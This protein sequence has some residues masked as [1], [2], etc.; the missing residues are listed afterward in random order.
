MSSVPQGPGKPEPGPDDAAP[1]RAAVQ[2][3]RR[4]MVGA[5]ATL[6][7]GAGAAVQ[8]LRSRPSP[9]AA[10]EPPWS[11]T[12]DRPD[13]SRMAMAVYLGQPVVLNF[14]ATWCPPCVREMPALD[15]FQR[16]FRSRG[17]RVI[18]IAAD[19]PQSVQEFLARVPV[20]LDI[21]LAGF[22]GIELSRQLGNESGGLPF[23]VV[24][25]RHGRVVHRHA[26][27]S[28]FEQ[29]VDWASGIS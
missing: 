21:A 24:Y 9:T 5:T 18:G 15:R 4:L 6:A 10:T 17:W 19:T 3:R 8:W 13:G 27:E 29:L 7:V 14:W 22:A 2:R 25:D 1:G 26:G 12:F 16:E 20:S 28:R 11:L 23:T